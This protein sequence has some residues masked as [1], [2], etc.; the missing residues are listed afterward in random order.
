MSW[1]I[2]ITQKER[3]IPYTKLDKRPEKGYTKPLAPLKPEDVNKLSYFERTG[4]THPWMKSFS[5]KRW[6]QGG[7]ENKKEELVGTQ[8]T[9]P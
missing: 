2:V 5:L 7:L 1:E 9:P 6:K 3:I 8:L 4:K